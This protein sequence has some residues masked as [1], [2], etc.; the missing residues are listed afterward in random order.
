MKY[1]FKLAEIATGPEE[2]VEL[3]NQINNICNSNAKLRNIVYNS[4]NDYK[5]FKL[6]NEAFL[7]AL[8]EQIK[9]NNPNLSIIIEPVI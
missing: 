6:I 8:I 7:Q 9:L 4:K 2:A 1:T 5:P 3:V